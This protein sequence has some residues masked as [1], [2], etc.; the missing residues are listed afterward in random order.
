MSALLDLLPSQLWQIAQR[1]SAY[2][3]LNLVDDPALLT[4]AFC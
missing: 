3:L 1:L 4:L 2:A